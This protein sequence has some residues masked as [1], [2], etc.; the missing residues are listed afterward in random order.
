MTTDATASDSPVPPQPPAAR[1]VLIVDDHPVFRRGMAALIS[2][3]TE[4]TVCA[5]AENAATALDAMRQFAPE[6]VLLDISLPGTNGIELIKLMHAEQPGLA[7]LIVSM[8]DESL[9]ALRA[10]RAGA[11]GYIMK[12]EGQS[13]LIEA[14]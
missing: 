5:E 13:H 9:Y 12:G 3:V 6:A 8:H 11:K 1:R 4:F 7:I 10:L 2:E 14:L